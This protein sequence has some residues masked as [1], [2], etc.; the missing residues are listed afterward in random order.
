MAA[1]TT[2][3]RARAELAARV[4]AGTLAIHDPP[5]PLDRADLV[6]DEGASLDLL[7][8]Q[9]APRPSELE[10][11]V[12]TA[13]SPVDYD[14]TVR[15]SVVIQTIRRGSSS[16]YAAT[17]EALE[18]IWGEVVGAL[19]GAPNVTGGTGDPSEDGIELI[20]RAPDWNAGYLP[21]GS[22]FMARV[23]AEVACSARLALE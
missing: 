11:E 12:F 13:A 21:D 4:T 23:V 8:I 5:G 14:E 22:G 3:L 9:D 19:A 10:I 18:K 16:T 6:A 15:L 2:T 7:W 20:L 17:N 1:I